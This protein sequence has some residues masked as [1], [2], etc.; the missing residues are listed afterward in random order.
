MLDNS[1]K[2]QVE[3]LHQARS[4]ELRAATELL[5][6]RQACLA[7]AATIDAE[8]KDYEADER[9]R[10]RRRRIAAKKLANSRYLDG[11]PRDLPGHG[12]I[13]R[14]YDREF[15]NKPRRAVPKGIRIV[16]QQRADLERLISARYGGQLPNDE[17]GEDDL[18]IA[19]NLTAR[20][21]G[22]I[23]KNFVAWVRRWAPWC[24]ETW[25]REIIAKVCDQPEPYRF[26]A[27]ILA[28]KQGLTYAERQALGITSIGAID[29]D[30]EERERLRR[31]RSRANERAKRRANGVIPR[32]LYEQGSANSTKPW[33]LKG[34]SKSTH[35]RRLRAARV[36]RV[37]DQSATV[38]EGVETV[39]AQTVSERELVRSHG[40]IDRDFQQPEER[41]EDRDTSS[42]SADCGAVRPA[43]PPVST[44]SRAAVDASS[45]RLVRFAP[46]LGSPC[47]RSRSAKE[48][49]NEECGLG[50]PQKETPTPQNADLAYETHRLQVAHEAYLRIR[51]R[52]GR[53]RF[54]K[55]LFSPGG[56]RQPLRL[57]PTPAEA[58]RKLLRGYE[59]GSC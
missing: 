30:G 23:S 46:T 6:A 54:L 4:R 59:E 52:R 25:A 57:R 40:R 43:Q 24:S 16:M 44:A 21:G 41:G 55:L 58:I 38:G 26:S 20:L 51:S 11:S 8:I 12:E 49:S 47:A 50:Q 33:K 1:P 2:A 7:R 22:D 3:H 10:N 32:K 27:D 42:R 53:R 56:I 34:I 17:S 29:V 37:Q 19:A 39:R 28:E 13:L 5:D 31:Q 35:Y 36:T 9:S 15:E 45:Q 18:F 48:P 14:R